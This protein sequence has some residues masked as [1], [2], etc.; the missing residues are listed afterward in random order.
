M[1]FLVPVRALERLVV[2]PTH[3]EP[4]SLFT[5][6]LNLVF[7]FYEETCLPCNFYQTS[8]TRI[9]HGYVNGKH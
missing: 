9:G 1:F 8:L 3:V 5:P 4:L 2:V 6:E 7:I